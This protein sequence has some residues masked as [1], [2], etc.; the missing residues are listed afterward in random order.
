M[1]ICM[2]STDS[3]PGRD[4]TEI[5]NP[6]NNA[7]CYAASP[8]PIDGIYYTTR[9]GEFKL[10]HSPYGIFDQTGNVFERCEASTGTERVRRGGWLGS[11]PCS[12][13]NRID[14]NPSLQR[15]RI[16]GGEPFSLAY[17]HRDPLNGGGCA[18]VQAYELASG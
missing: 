15:Y 17:T 4:L 3:V 14:D 16:P 18:S 1:T 6:G 12:A 9:V 10:S 8:Y 7:N 5:T 11:D 13:A 2:I